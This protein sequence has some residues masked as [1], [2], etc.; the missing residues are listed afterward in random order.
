MAENL[1]KLPPLPTAPTVKQPSGLE[2]LG[3][4][5]GLFLIASSRPELLPQAAQKLFA[6]RE[7]AERE[8]ELRFQRELELTKTAVGM[9]Q[10][11]GA[12]ARA[13]RQEQ[14]QEKQ[15]KFARQQARQE[16]GLDVQREQRLA[17]ADAA[18]RAHQKFLEEMSGR[19][20]GEAQQTHAMQVLEILSKRYDEARES[21]ES[22][23]GV[24]RTTGQG[25]LATMQQAQQ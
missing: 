2:Q 8:A 1:P 17:A 4:M 22:Q 9:Q 6:N 25:R 3:N 5:A 10:A 12:E 20:L 15:D 13:G 7:E 11:A 24:S 23:L 21:V 18:Q 16:F 14:R 19:Q